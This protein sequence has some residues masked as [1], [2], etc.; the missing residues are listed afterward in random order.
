M[1]QN[2]ARAKCKGDGVMIYAP[3]WAGEGVRVGLETGVGRPPMTMWWPYRNSRSL[4]M[5][6]PQP[7]HCCGRLG[8]PAAPTRYLRN[9]YILSGLSCAHS[10]SE[11]RLVG[12]PHVAAPFLL[13]LLSLSLS[14]SGLAS[15]E[16]ARA[17]ACASRLTATNWT[18]SL[19]PL[20]FPVSFS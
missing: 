19:R 9:A 10:I 1:P 4:H 18:L 5:Q 14:L 13:L 2:L 16:E 11:D 3:N 8:Y 7:L 17:V 20:G 6:Q 15:S 12:L